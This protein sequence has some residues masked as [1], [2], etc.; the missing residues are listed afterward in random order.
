[1][2]LGENLLDADGAAENVA[3]DQCRLLVAL[4][5]LVLGHVDRLPFPIDHPKLEQP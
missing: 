2:K 4:C 5:D 3:R 1:M